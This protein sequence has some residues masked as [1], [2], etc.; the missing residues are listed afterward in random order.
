MKTIV[1]WM[2]TLSTPIL[3][4][5][6]STD[7]STEIYEGYSFDN[8]LDLKKYALSPENSD[9]EYDIIGKIHNSVL[10]IYLSENHN[11]STVEEIYNEV[12]HH[13]H[14]SG[15]TELNSAVP[16][17]DLIKQIAIVRDAPEHSLNKIIFE[18][19]LST[20]AKTS[21]S[22]FIS[23]L[24][25]LKDNDY[26]EI[27]DF[28]LLYEGSIIESTLF[29]SEDKRIILTTSALT[30]YSSN[31]EKPRKDKDWETSVGNIAITVEGALHDAQTAIN[32]ALVAAISTNTIL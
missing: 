8:E 17:P 27:Y 20:S 28:I 24:M 11:Y 30:R 14:N 12:R 18:S 29:S 7:E 2:I 32:M 16:L 31:D 21:L 19:H 9:N 3:L 10:E 1:I 4:T 23:S 6:C 5:S 25:L 26:A 22:N 13:V 15:H